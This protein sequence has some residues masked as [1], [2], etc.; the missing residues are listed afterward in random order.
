[1]ISSNKKLESHIHEKLGARVASKFECGEIEH[2]QGDDMHTSGAK[3]SRPSSLHF[4]STQQLKNDQKGLD[5]I[6]KYS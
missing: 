3:L 2:D 6:P 4:K 1:M 5:Y